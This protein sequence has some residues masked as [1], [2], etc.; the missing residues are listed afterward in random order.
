MTDTSSHPDHSSEMAPA[1]ITTPAAAPTTS[2]PAARPRRSRAWLIAGGSV[3]AAALI[4]GGGIAVGAAIGDEMDDDDDR[5]SSDAGAAS[6]GDQSA[7]IGTESAI[8][9]ADIIDAASASAEGAAVDI[10]AGRDGSWDVTFETSAG[11]ETQ[12]RVTANGT[13]QVVSTD[14]ASADDVAPQGVLDADTVDAL[15]TAAMAE[16]SGRITDIEIDDDTASPFDISVVQANGR[17]VDLDL[18]ADMKVLS[19]SP[20]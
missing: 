1:A 8:E 11:E 13:A 9:L 17:T 3:L 18:D 19:I 14:A 12:V 5:A 16:V 10:E 2:E 15:V 7:D 20:S 4:A 6:A